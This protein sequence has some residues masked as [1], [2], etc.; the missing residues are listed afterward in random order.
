M[1][2][3]F[4]SWWG[5]CSGK[6][7]SSIGRRSIFFGSHILTGFKNSQSLAALANCV[8]LI[9]ILFGFLF[10]GTVSADGSAGSGGAF[11]PFAFGYRD[12]QSG[13]TDSRVWDI[14]IPAGFTLIKPDED[15]WGLRLRLTIY[16]GGY[17]VNINE[18]SD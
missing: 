3:K 6:S 8:L 4:F 12:A 13:N 14:R 17:D 10:V 16:A 7:Q 1:A 9:S 2:A 15:T 5:P 11:H 18:P